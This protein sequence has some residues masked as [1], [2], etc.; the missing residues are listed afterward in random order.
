MKFKNLMILIILIIIFSIDAVYADELEEVTK[1]TT[2]SS[3]YNKYTNNPYGYE[4][5]ILNSLELNEEIVS[6][7]SRFESENLVVEVLYDN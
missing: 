4:M 7:K 1:L 6:V 3:T 2:Y 5:T